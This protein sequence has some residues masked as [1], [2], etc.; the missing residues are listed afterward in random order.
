[1][2]ML[3]LGFLLPGAAFPLGGVK[4]GCFGRKARWPK[5]LQPVS[6]KLQ[7]GLLVERAEGFIRHA[8]AFVCL[9]P[10]QFIGLRHEQP[11]TFATSKR[12][13]NANVPAN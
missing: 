4:L 3:A 6:R 1:G 11:L 5:Q 7:P 8:A 2:L 12:K 10:V 9:C 13:K